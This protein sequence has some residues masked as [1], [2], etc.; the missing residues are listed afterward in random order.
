MWEKWAASQWQF[1]HDRLAHRQILDSGVETSLWLGV[2]CS[3][4]SMLTAETTQV[5]NVQWNGC[6]NLFCLVNHF[7]EGQKRLSNCLAWKQ[8]IIEWG[9]R[10]TGLAQELSRNLEL[11]TSFYC[12]SVDKGK[13]VVCAG[14]GKKENVVK[15]ILFFSFVSPPHNLFCLHPQGSQGTESLC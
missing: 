15:I 4:Q 11:S 8:N 12:V 5:K 13:I 3:A 7:L 9:I 1:Q 6:H 14:K 10:V 2:V